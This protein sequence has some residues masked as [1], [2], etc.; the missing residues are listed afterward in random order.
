ME[1]PSRPARH[2]KPVVQDS[3]ARIL[4]VGLPQRRFI[5]SH[6]RVPAAF[7]SFVVAVAALAAM[8]AFAVLLVDSHLFA[9]KPASTELGSGTAGDGLAVRRA[10]GS[11]LR[12]AVAAGEAECRGV[13]HCFQDRF[14]WG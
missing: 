5:R 13:A 11:G 12:D 8:D 9:A 7:L 6:G 3:W 4:E 2:A 14:Q 10:R 1:C